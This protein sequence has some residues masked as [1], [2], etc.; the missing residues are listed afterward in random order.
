MRP[1]PA[2]RVTAL[3]AEQLSHRLMVSEGT[4]LLPAVAGGK[5]GERQRGNDFER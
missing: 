1:V 4:W 3:L 5:G 2:P